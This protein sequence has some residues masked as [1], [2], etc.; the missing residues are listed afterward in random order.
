MSAA[1]TAVACTVVSLSG[2]VALALSD[3]KRLRKLNRASKRSWRIAGS[4]LALAPGLWLIGTAQGVAFLLWLGASAVF[5][6][7]IAALLPTAPVA[8][9][10]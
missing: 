2:I 4:V 3:P 10:R 1:L 7:G 8:R 5:G 6:W 9:H